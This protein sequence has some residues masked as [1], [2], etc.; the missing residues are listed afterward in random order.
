MPRQ[1]PGPSSS[2][3]PL[4][5]LQNDNEIGIKSGKKD[6]NSHRVLTNHTFRFVL[7]L[8]EVLLNKLQVKVE[9]DMFVFQFSI[10]SHKLARFLRK[11]Q[12]TDIKERLLPSN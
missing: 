9:L 7:C 1:V 10:A 6:K 11:S 3:P 12:S 2:E 4:F 8:L 5:Y